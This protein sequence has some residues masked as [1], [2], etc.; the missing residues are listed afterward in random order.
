MTRP[1][2]VPPRFDKE[3]LLEAQKTNQEICAVVRNGELEFW[4]NVALDKENTFEM[5]TS[6]Q[7]VEAVFHSHP[8]GPFYPSARDMQQ[9]QATA[10]PWA[11]AAT[12]A[13][14]NEVFWWGEQVPKSP[15]VGRG[16]RHGITDCY[17]LVRDF[18]EMKH[19]IRLPNFPRSWEWWAEGEN[20]YQEG[21]AEAGFREV[22]ISDIKPGDS[23]MAT[24]RSPAINHAGVYL[25]NGLILHHTCGK[26]GFD[27]SR[28]SVV[29]PAARWMNFVT[30]V[31]R[32]END[33]IDRRAGQGIRP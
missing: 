22:P 9:Q 33:S 15:L 7:G 24:I 25:G 26:D 30:K 32:H 5:R 2:H 19:G 1:S 28:L 14:H 3:F 12:H 11:I 17:E 31:V 20:L 13:E 29:E 6:M 23:F 10:T 16:F 18:Y 21:F 8:G 27:P 4:E